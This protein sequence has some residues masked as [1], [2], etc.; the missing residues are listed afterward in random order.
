LAYLHCAVDRASLD[1]ALERGAGPLAAVDRL[2]GETVSLSE[3]DFDDLCRVHLYDWLEQV[4]RSR[5]GWDYRRQTYRRVAERLGG[6][7]REAYDSVF[8]QEPRTAGL[9]G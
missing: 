2:T 8:A 9:S 1:A 4:P 3:D 5:F 6:P 7:A